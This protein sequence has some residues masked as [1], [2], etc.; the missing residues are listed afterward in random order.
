MLKKGDFVVLG[1]TA[2]AILLS[3]AVWFFPRNTGKTVTVRAENKVVY[4]APLGK[5]AT[6]KLDGNTIVVKNGKAYVS[7][8]N[9]RNQICV[10]HAPICRAGDTILCLP[11]RVSVTVE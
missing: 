3:A 2:A 5:D 7:W 10:H 1:V 4:S 9:C 11:H 6:V 8:A